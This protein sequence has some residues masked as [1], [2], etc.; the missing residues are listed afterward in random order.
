[1]S[2]IQRQI[3]AQGISTVSISLFRGFAEKVKP[4][5][6]LWVPFPFGRPLGAP[7][8]KA[9]QRKV[10]FAML[11]LLK[12]DQAPILEDLILTSEEDHLDARNQKIGQKCGTKGCNFDD[13]LASEE[14]QVPREIAKYDGDFA[15]VCA[16]I[17]ARKLHHDSYMRDYNGRT[18]IGYSGVAV[19]AIEIAATRLN[20]FI[21]GQ[22]LSIPKSLSLQV[23]HP[24]VAQNAFIR[25][26]ADDLKAYYLESRL[27]E[28]KGEGSEKSTEYNDWLWYETRMG[29]LIV[30]ARARVIETTDRTKDPN[31]MIARAMVPRGYG[32]SGYTMHSQNKV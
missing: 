11:D 19:D 4:P 6:A 1:M 10:I 8:N 30:A 3:E 2:V 5:R 28:K 13:A 25:L 16:E 7:N 12:R 14:P 21:N 22:E 17:A 18:Q 31:W 15:G 29:S 9:I 23:D 24:A 32:E 27:S 20:D 26:C